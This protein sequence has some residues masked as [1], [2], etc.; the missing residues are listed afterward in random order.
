[1]KINERNVVRFATSAS[2]VD[3]QGFLLKRGEVNRSFQ[4]RYFVL[5][6]NLL[7]YFERRDDA[8]PCGVI[9]LE[10]CTVELAEDEREP[11]SFNVVF[12][13]AGART[14]VLSADSQESMEAWMRRVACAGYDYVKTMVAELQR[15]LEELEDAER[16][17]DAARPGDDPAATQGSD[18]SLTSSSSSSRGGRPRFN[19]FNKIPAVGEADIFCVRASAGRGGDARRSPSVTSSRSH[20]SGASSRES[21]LDLHEQFGAKIRK[22][23]EERKSSSSAT[24]PV[25]RPS[26]TYLSSV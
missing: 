9:I 3:R 23:I 24:A 2:V 18:G 25:E 19:P 11:Y 7:F 13:G 8:E 16:E 26:V 15:Q 22:Q 14:Y 1:M 4:K 6:G 5:K 17:T 12:H 20:G 21:F 10:G